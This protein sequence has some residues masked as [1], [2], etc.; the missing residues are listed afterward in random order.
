M[1]QFVSVDAG[2][3]FGF[4]SDFFGGVDFVFFGVECV[5]GVDRVSDFEAEGS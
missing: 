3:G 5:V 2:S 1:E 4:G